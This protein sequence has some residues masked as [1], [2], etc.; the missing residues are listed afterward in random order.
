[1]HLRRAAATAGIAALTLALTAC[2][3]G[4]GTPEP[5][6]D[7]AHVQ[8][9][10]ST[11]VYGS[12][13]Q[14]V[15]GEHVAVTSI[16]DD[17]A[18]DP[19]EYE[20]TPADA[21]AVGKAA[22]VIVNGGGY[23]DFAGKLVEAAGTT[24][25]TIDVSRLSGLE[26]A[27]PAGEEFNEHVW[28]HLPTVKKLADQLAADLG[29]ADPADAAAFTANAA[30]FNARIDGLIA[31]VDA[32]KS[33]HGGQPVAITE[34][35]PVYLAEAAGLRNLTPA[36]FT[37]AAEE[38]SDPP[39]AVLTETLALF[40]GKSVKVLLLNGQAESPATH[41]VEQAAAA[42]A[43]PVVRVTE[44]LPAGDG[45]YLSWQTQQIDALAAALG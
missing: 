20:T 8:V 19:H 30:A 18:K 44:T 5:A 24:P 1:M 26:A 16:I 33:A 39:A 45:D 13:A 22:I 41:Q 42:A 28:Y 34:P 23:D 3:N 31:K 40:T 37:E 27:A 12:I 6:A 36:E 43:I 9:V 35:V 17:P 15:G 7:E 14:A 11:D 32:I 10:A 2:G 4:A 25:T 21:L 38:G 29:K